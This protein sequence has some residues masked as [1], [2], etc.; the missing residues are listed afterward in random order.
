M[1]YSRIKIGQFAAISKNKSGRQG[2]L[3][4]VILCSYLSF[5]HH[6]L[7]RPVVRLYIFV[8]FHLKSTVDLC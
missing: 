1:M 6:H 4:V 7:L 8:F 2:L 3:F 5:I